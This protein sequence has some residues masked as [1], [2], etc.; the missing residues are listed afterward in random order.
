MPGTIMRDAL[1]SNLMLGATLTIG[2]TNGTAV[3]V[4]KPG[5]CRATLTLGAVAGTNPTLQVTLQ[6][7]DDLAFTVNVR[8]ID[9]FPVT[10]GTNAAQVGL[11]F[12]NPVEVWANY[13]RAI[14]VVG[15]ADANYVGTT[16]YL[17]SAHDRET[18]TTD[19]AGN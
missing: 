1:A 16:L 15:A 9:A 19:R 2:T 11:V 14:V 4:A 6:V 3:K 18:H 8:K 12:V 10:T 13:V 7:A 17:R 5:P